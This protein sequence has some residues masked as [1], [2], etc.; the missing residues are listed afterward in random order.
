[1]SGIYVLGP[2]AYKAY[3]DWDKRRKSVLVIPF[4]RMKIVERCSFGLSDLAD[5]IQTDENK[6]MEGSIL[7]SYSIS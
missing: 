2:Q 7:I 3:K 5:F 6:P 1:M 4:H